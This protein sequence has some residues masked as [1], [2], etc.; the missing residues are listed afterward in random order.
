MK[1]LI[2]LTLIAFGATATMTALTPPHL[3]AVTNAAGG[4]AVHAV[5]PT[6]S[7]RDGAPV[8][9]EVEVDHLGEKLSPEDYAALAN[10][11]MRGLLPPVEFAHPYRGRVRLLRGQSQEALRHLCGK[12]PEGV[13]LGCARKPDTNGVPFVVLADDATV[14]A[15]G[16]TPNLNALHEAGHLNGAWTHDG[17]RDLAQL[18]T[19]AALPQ[20]IEAPKPV[21]VAQADAPPPVEEDQY[22]E[23][24]PP[25]RHPRPRYRD[26][27]PYAPPSPPYYGPPPGWVP[28]IFGPA[29]CLPQLLGIQACL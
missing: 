25:R 4:P 26:D 22:V 21:V 3:S 19:A 13:L 27:G 17:W 16:W 15:N 10:A 11:N 7:S 1:P 8:T 28:T 20:P 24:P 12:Q 23:V 29:P 14:R 2:N 6:V 5:R 18:G 9:T